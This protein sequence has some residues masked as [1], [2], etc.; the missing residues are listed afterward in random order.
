MCR[1]LSIS[2]KIEYQKTKE[3]L[4]KFQ[5]LA[6][7]G[8]VPGDAKGGHKD[9]W[10]IV[11]YRKKRPIFQ[12][13]N[14]KN[15]FCDPGYQESVNKLEKYNF[16]IIV[17]H[18]RKASVGVKNI[19]NTHPFVLGKYSFC[20]NG[21]VFNSEKI[22]LDSKLK[23][24]LKGTTDSERLFA[25]ILQNFKKSK[26]KN[27]EAITLAI[28]KSVKFVRDKLNYTAIN[29]IFSDG[30]NIWALREVNEKNVLVRKYKLLNYYSLF[31]GSDGMISIISSEKLKIKNIKWQVLKNH[32]LIKTE[33]G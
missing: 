2:G 21:T 30:K 5:E 4:E 12:T 13:R 25:Y 26:K 16:K 14:Y 9:G 27:S 31:I 1:I 20:Q 18:L 28:K 15:A 17:A 3:A 11:A 6:E 23:K 29:M 7:R 33:G 10:G 22:P 24:M 32:E 19:N 8:K